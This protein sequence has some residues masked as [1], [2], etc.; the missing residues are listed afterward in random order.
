[1]NKQG[2]GGSNAVDEEEKRQVRAMAASARNGGGCAFGAPGA[3]RMSTHPT[4]GTERKRE[5]E[6][7]SP[8]RRCSA[9]YTTISAITGNV[10]RENTVVKKVPR[11]IVR[12]SPS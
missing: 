1:M 3:R 10:I 11:D 5:R 2:K 12:V 7:Q 6:N 8:Q 4:K 9:R